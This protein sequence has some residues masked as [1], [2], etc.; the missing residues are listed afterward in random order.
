MFRVN[1]KVVCI[2]DSIKPGMETFV[3]DAYYSWVKK[4][5]E[6]SI[7][8]VLDN[9]GIVVGLLLN[10]IYNFPIYQELLKREQEPCFSTTRFRKLESATK[11]EYFSEENSILEEEFIKI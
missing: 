3:K 8:Q 11:E 6:Y 10:E 4:D 1:D 7:R 2:D 5:R 9:D